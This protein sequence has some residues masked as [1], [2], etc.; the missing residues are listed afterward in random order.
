[1]FTKITHDDWMGITCILVFLTGIYIHHFNPGLP[2][3]GIHTLLARYY[4]LIA[5]L[6]GTKGFILLIVV[7]TLLQTAFGL[8]LHFFQMLFAWVP[9]RQRP[10]SSVNEASVDLNATNSVLESWMEEDG[11]EAWKQ[12]REAAGDREEMESDEDSLDFLLRATDGDH[13]GSPPHSPAAPQQLY[14]LSI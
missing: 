7:Y 4:N 13:A 8:L 3:Y 1:M 14:L 5:L 2:R 10:A 6:T 9:S 11:E 12:K